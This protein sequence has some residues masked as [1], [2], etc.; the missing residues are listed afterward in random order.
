MTQPTNIRE[1]MKIEKTMWGL[2]VPFLLIFWKTGKPQRSVVRFLFTRTSE[3]NCHF[4]KN[5]TFFIFV[6]S[7]TSGNV[8]GPLNTL[9]LT[10]D[11]PN[12]SNPLTSPSKLRS[13]AHLPAS[14]ASTASP[15]LHQKTTS[16]NFQAC[17]QSNKNQKNCS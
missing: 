14:Q 6:I 4:L 3:L 17:L 7:G 12:N 1:F 2:E 8:K 9:F 15:L 10:L 11:P 16:T 13:Q 5:R